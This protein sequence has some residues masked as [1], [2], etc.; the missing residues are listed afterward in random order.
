MWSQISIHL[1]TGRTGST[2]TLV[3]LLLLVGHT[4]RGFLHCICSVESFATPLS[5][6]VWGRLW[7]GFHVSCHRAHCCKNVTQSKVLVPCQPGFLAFIRSGWDCCTVLTPCAADG[8]CKAQKAAK[9]FCSLYK[10]K[11]L[12]TINVCSRCRALVFLPFYPLQAQHGCL[13]GNRRMLR[14]CLGFFLLQRQERPA[15]WPCV[16]LRVLLCQ[17]GAEG[18][19]EQGITLPDF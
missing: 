12:G 8:W 17:C 5:Q 4:S 18:L 10:H 11:A 15:C 7:S 2:A 3:G 1:S 19:R 9:L 13:Q 6:R 14:A 16:G